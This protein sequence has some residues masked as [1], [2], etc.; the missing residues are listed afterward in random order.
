MPRVWVSCRGT[1]FRPSMQPPQQK[2]LCLALPC[3]RPPPPPHTHRPP[4]QQPQPAPALTSSVLAGAAEK[5]TQ[6]QQQAVTRAQVCHYSSIHH[7]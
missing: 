2:S 7:G 4:V 3:A 5:L 6:Q 1:H